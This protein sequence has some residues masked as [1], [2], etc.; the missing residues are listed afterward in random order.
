MLTGIVKWFD[1]DK[2]FGFIVPDDGGKDVFVHSSDIEA[3]DENLRT[4]LD[5]QHVEFELQI[6]PK[7][8]KAKK[9]KVKPTE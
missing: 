7:G 1:K 9:V 4:L 6:G 3:E 5:G 8:R 2:G